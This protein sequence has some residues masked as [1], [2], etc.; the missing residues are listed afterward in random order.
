MAR[1]K[2]VNVGGNATCRPIVTTTGALLEEALD[3]V[4]G[5]QVDQRG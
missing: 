5:C 2:P 4:V 3:W 1:A